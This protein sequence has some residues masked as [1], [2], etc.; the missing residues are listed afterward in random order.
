MCC[1]I[2]IF[3]LPGRI[4]KHPAGRPWKYNEKVNQ[5]YIICDDQISQKKEKRPLK[6]TNMICLNLGPVK[7]RKPINVIYTRPPM[8]IDHVSCLNIIIFS[9][10]TVFE[11]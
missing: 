11:I 7:K 2:L 4:P 1:L 10:M 6:W 9:H 8:W 5:Y 3:G